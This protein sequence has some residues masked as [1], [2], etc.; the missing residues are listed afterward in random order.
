MNTQQALVGSAD[1]QQ[2]FLAE[3]VNV[4]LFD[5]K[6]EASEHGFKAGES[7]NIR[8]ATD[9]EITGLRRNNHPVLSLKLQSNELLRAYLHI[10]GRLEQSLT[11]DDIAL[12]ADDLAKNEKWHL[13]AYPAR[14]FR[15]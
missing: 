5:L 3:K 10:K 9:N 14:S 8:V 15:S 2:N 6:N 12:T 13:A 11:K 1:A 7:W 4:F